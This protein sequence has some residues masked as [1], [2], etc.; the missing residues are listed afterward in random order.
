MPLPSPDALIVSA[1]DALL[2]V[3][4]R[5]GVPLPKV[6]A[7]AYLI[8]PVPFLGVA[9]TMP[10]VGQIWF[11]PMWLIVA[12]AIGFASR[13][14]L[15]SL[16]AD[17][18]GWSP[19]K[20]KD[21]RARAQ[22]VRERQAGSRML[23]LVILAFQSVAIGYLLRMPALLPLVLNIAAYGGLT[24]FMAVTLYVR[25]AM[26]HDPDLTRRATGPVLSPT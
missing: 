19:Q 13:H 3:P 6:V 14:I 4:Q 20:A 26:P 10:G 2:A 17:A 9:A 24:L 16:K 8:A 25:C 22:F 7:P 21:W 15:R 5:R 23:L 11:V 18:E 1:T 12:A